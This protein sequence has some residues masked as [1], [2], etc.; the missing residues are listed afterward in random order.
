[1]RRRGKRRRR[2]KKRRRRRRKYSYSRLK[3]WANMKLYSQK[4]R[5]VREGGRVMVN[6]ASSYQNVIQ[7]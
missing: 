5:E 3:P 2:R 7:N 4:A 6:R 1:M